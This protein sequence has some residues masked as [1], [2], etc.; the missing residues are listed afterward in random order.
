MSEDNQNDIDPEEEPSFAE[1]L[2]SY[3]AGMNEDIQVG[4]K[5][6]GKIISISTESVFVDTGTKADGIVEKD[7]LLDDEGKFSHDIGDTLEL[8][9]V[10]ADESE[11]KLSRAMSGI[12]GINMLKEAHESGVPVEG[13]VIGT[14]KGGFHVEAF[15]RRTFCPISQIDTRFVENPEEY[16]GQA[17][18]FIVRQ[19][20]ENGR[21]VVLSRRAILEKEQEAARKA[22]FNDLDPDA[23]LEGRVTKIMPY[24][25]FV[26]LIPGVEGMVHISELSWSRLDTPEDAVKP[27]ENLRVKILSIKEGNKPGQK[28]IAL[29]VKQAHGDPWDFVTDK[30]SAGEKVH[31]KVTR[32][33]NFGAFVELEPGIEGLV[34]IS[35]MSYTKRILNPE[36]EV[37]A[38]EKVMVMIKEIDVDKRRISLS[39]RDAIGDPWAHVEENFPVGSS[40][41][42][43]IEKKEKF[44]YFVTLEPGVT[45][46]LPKSKISKSENSA[47]VEKLK[48]GDQITVTVDEIKVNE[49]KISLGTGD[50][51]DD[52]DWREFAEKNDDNMGALG[53]QLK[54]AMREK[55]ES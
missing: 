37:S 39:I 45:G 5:V 55:K 52:Q 24:G 40:V 21:N 3:S 4:D 26:E 8:Y 19:F 15:K 48:V 23:V 36:D 34:H 20:E 25:A 43:K 1:M 30:Y 27:G 7:E 41:T 46:L 10:A 16:V 32:C 42:G 51:V 29:S 33:M 12:G 49:R 22:F 28:K 9:V 50:K 47:A 11:I 31:G 44:G 18:T 35:E 53:E 13:K 2:E 17:L 54:A 6:R 38:G 14:V